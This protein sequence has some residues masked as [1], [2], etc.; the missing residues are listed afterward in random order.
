VSC[1]AH[2][3]T[4]Q[5]A[6]DRRHKVTVQLQD[7]ALKT[8]KAGKDVDLSLVRPGDIVTIQ[9]GEGLVVTLQKS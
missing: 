5:S 8:V 9:L 3:G 7:G 2:G 1:A 4:E 6:V